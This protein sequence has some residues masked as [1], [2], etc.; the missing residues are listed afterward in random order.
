MTQGQANMRN[1]GKACYWHSSG[2]SWTASVDLY[3]CHLDVQHSI[4]MQSKLEHWMLLM[5]GQGGR[6]AGL[7]A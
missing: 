7:A 4:G 1:V 3:V 2:V 6:L 5:H